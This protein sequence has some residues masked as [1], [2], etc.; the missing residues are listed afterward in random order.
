MN[1]RQLKV[2]LSVMPKNDIP[3]KLNC[4]FVDFD[5]SEVVAC[6]G[7]MIGL[8]GTGSVLIP[9]NVVEQV[10]K[11]KTKNTI[12]FSNTEI[13]VDDFSFPFTPLQGTYPDYS[14]VIP[15]NEDLKKPGQFGF[16]QSKCIKVI[17]ELEAAFEVCPI[18]H[19]PNKKGTPLKAT[20]YAG[21]GERVIACVMP[22]SVRT[23]ETYAAMK[24]CI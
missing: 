1:K 14:K 11:T 2:L 16:Y 13:S 9:R 3:Y 10:A 23:T 15:P 8:N 19:R 5:K 18:F 24:A 20:F 4:L 22:K 21:S 6:N 12:I 17:E 7:F